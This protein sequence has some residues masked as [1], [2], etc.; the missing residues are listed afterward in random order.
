MAANGNEGGGYT[1]FSTLKRQGVARPAK[2]GMQMQPIK[3]IGGQQPVLKAPEEDPNKKKQQAGMTPVNNTMNA[4]PGQLPGG[5]SPPPPP[6]PGGPQIA[7][8]APQ[9]TP[10]PGLETY[11]GPMMNSTGQGTMQPMPAP[12]AMPQAQPGITQVPMQ[13]MQPG[14][15]GSIP[16]QPGYNGPGS[17]GPNIAPPP[18]GQGNPNQPPPNMEDQ[19]YQNW[20]QGQQGQ[21][22]PTGGG[23]Y[24][25]PLNP[26]IQQTISDQLKNPSRYDTQMAKDTYDMMN[27]Q[28][29]EGYNTQ[30]NQVDEQMANRG[31]FNSTTAGGRLGDLRTNQARAQADMGQNILMDQART[32]SGDINA[33]TGAALGYGQAG[34]QE[35]GQNYGNQA[36]TYGMNVNKNQND[37]ENYTGYGQQGFENQMATG[38]Y[39]Q[40][41]DRINND[42]LMQLL[43]GL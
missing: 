37:Y 1:T 16:G 34:R 2:P 29:S 22:N 12:Q 27:R 38:R 23:Q 6:A 7:P 31:L 5:A 9:G 42:L 17:G 41:Q 36:Q 18:P 28:L 20:Q 15:F 19:L 21:F 39:N 3:P 13:P 10:Q 32:Y 14:G 40:D 43:G 24:Q 11:N 25:N 8:Q 35:A 4:Q 33:A 26:Q 30:A